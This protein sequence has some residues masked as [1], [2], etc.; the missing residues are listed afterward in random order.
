ME[1]HSRQSL[2]EV[3]GISAEP[4]RR[5]PRS[6]A[7]LLIARIVGFL[8]KAKRAIGTELAIRRAMT[9]LAGMD[10]HMLRDLGI[11]RSEIED[12]LRRQRASIGT[13]DAS[14]LEYGR[15]EPPV[16]ADRQLSADGL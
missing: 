10:D 7:P 6:I 4:R 11:H 9:E 16:F 14:F 13:D 15:S 1:M 8:M 2:Y 3:H 12:R 5:R